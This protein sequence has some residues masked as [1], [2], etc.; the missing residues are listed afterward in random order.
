MDAN[1]ARRKSHDDL[2]TSLRFFPRQSLWLGSVAHSDDGPLRSA[3]SALRS[4]ICAV[5][6]AVG[7]VTGSAAQ[8]KPS[9]AGH[10]A[11][12]PSF[13]PHDSL[14]TVDVRIENK[15]LRVQVNAKGPELHLRLEPDPEWKS[16]PD[17]VQRVGWIRVFSCET[18]ALVQ[19]LEVESRSDPE[20]F[21][22]FFEVRD[23]NFDD[24][25][26]IAVLR[27]FGGKWGR[28]T[29][30]VFSPASGKFISDELTKA[31]GEVSANGLILD[32]ARQ[33][34]V[35]P[36]LTNLTGCGATKDI[37]HVE[38]SRLVL[39]HKEDISVSPKGCTL[40]IRDRANGQMPVTKVRQFPPYHEPTTNQ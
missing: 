19:S 25:L 35:A 28:Q 38:Q 1:Q 17:A 29:W 16:T 18:G 8:A 3:A 4:A 33:N 30:W 10:C 31:L 11:G 26:D 12:F 7:L 24:Y 36:Q 9:E 13:G 14:N 32:A 27:E 2:P 22:R 40:T 37:Y 6:L 34:I 21:L 23:V 20:F 15:D 39:I 5:L